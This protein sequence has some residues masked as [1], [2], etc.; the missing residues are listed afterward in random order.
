MKSR[1]RDAESSTTSKHLVDK[2][3]KESASFRDE[4]NADSKITSMANANSISNI[5]RLQDIG[6][7]Y[8]KKIEFEKRRIAD[9]DE[10]IAQYEAKIK[11][12]RAKLGGAS[13]I[14]ESN[15][16]ITK[17]IKGL[18]NKLSKALQ[19]YNEAVA[20]NKQLRNQID[21]LRRER[22]VFDT[23][24]T[25]LEDELNQKR[26]EMKEVIEKSE[27]AQEERKKAERRM[28][29]LKDRAAKDQENF[30]QRW[31]QLAEEIEQDKNP[32]KSTSKF[33][34]LKSNSQ[35]AASS[36]GKTEEKVR[37][38]S[39]VHKNMGEQE[40]SHVAINDVKSHEEAFEK[41]KAATGIHD[42]DELVKFFVE[43]E[44]EN[45][46]LFNYVN[47]LNAELDKLESQVQDVKR[48]IDKFKD[49]GQNKDT[50]K[51]KLL[52]ELEEKLKKTERKSQ[53]YEERYQETMK[54]INA[55]KIGIHSIF[56]RI[57]CNNETVQEMLGVGGVT[58]ANM[59]QYLGIIEQRTNEIL[60]MYAACQAKSSHEL[61]STVANNSGSNPQLVINAN[62]EK[63]YD[64]G[65][66]LNSSFERS[67]S[68]SDEDPT[69]PLGKEELLDK[70]RKRLQKKAE[71]AKSKK[72]SK[73]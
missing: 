16:L 67:G 62:K 14:K 41:I 1:M 56:D 27:K 33:D 58:E 2:I 55:L 35:I 68:E 9:L 10:Q 72:A 5:A 13:G 26:K 51:K 4:L 54:T 24:Y 43:A 19:K 66:T 70:A 32:Q 30:N 71:N 29:D 6:D 3:K 17:K 47:E 7:S 18:E 59:M 60:Q 64:I 49:S 34:T 15:E 61:Q 39:P 69:L 65:A 25:K 46:S 53:I 36:P 8:A 44:D 40:G 21:Q 20:H 50:Q 28:R 23:I 57:G 22:K 42:I 37:K 63:K 38:S 12:S 31:K 11:E 48:E 45:Y 52:E 73:R